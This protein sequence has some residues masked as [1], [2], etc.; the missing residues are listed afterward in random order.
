[1]EDAASIT[2]FKVAGEFFCFE[3][4][5]IRHILEMTAPTPVPLSKD[6]I[7]GVVNNH[8]NMTPVVDFRKIIGVSA[9]ENLPEASIVVVAVDDS[10][11]SL[12]GFKVDEVDEVFATDN[13]NMSP[14]VV[15]EIDKTVQKAL[16]GTYHIGEK[17]I[18]KVNLEELAKVIEQ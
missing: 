18:Y 9:E 5:K 14:E 15:F 13:Y 12:I 2:S 3:T 6:Y 10:N 17:F 11:E 8:G 1:M 7:L 16:C 4:T